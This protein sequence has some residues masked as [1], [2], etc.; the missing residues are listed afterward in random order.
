MS[1]CA[2]V[3]LFAL[4]VVGCESPS[5][6]TSF[7]P[8]PGVPLEIGYLTSLTGPCA[9]FSR[10]SVRGA[11]RAVAAINQ[12]GGVLGHRLR[13][14]VRDDR[15]W[16]SVGVEQAR[17]LVLGA[18]VKYLA[19][20]CSRPVAIR[21]ARLVANPF[22]MIYVPALA[23]PTVFAGGQS[24]YVFDL[25]PTVDG[26]AVD[27]GFNQVQVIARGIEEANSTDPTAVREALDTSLRGH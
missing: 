27:D 5:S 3:S 13:L 19:G 16:P 9:T 8:A 24:S 17:D 26:G 1:V 23:A 15:E 14:F 7:P 11:K 4:T 25:P 22:Q 18:E 12:R 2:L 20:T 6:I 21:V 10:A